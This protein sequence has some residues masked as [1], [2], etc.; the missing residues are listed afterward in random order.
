MFFLNFHL[1]FLIA[2]VFIAI[3]LAETTSVCKPINLDTGLLYFEPTNDTDKNYPVSIYEG[4]LSAS[5]LEKQN[6]HLHLNNALFQVFVRMHVLNEL[7]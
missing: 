3:N 1:I 6:I 2:T 7:L 5:L 4:K